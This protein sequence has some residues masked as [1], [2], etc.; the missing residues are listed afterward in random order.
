MRNRFFFVFWIQIF[1]QCSFSWSDEFHRLY[2]GA[3]A[4][5]M[6][7]AF[8]AVAD[9]EEAIFYNPAGLAGIEKLGL[10]LLASDTDVSG[11]LLCGLNDYTSSF[12]NPSISTIRSMI[13]KKLY[14]REQVVST[15]LLPR[16]GFALLEDLQ[17][18]LRPKNVIFPDIFLGVQNTFGTQFAFGM[19]IKRF[20]NKRGELRIGLAAKMLWRSGGYQ[21]FPFEQ[22][23]LLNSSSLR[24]MLNQYGTGYGA[25]AGMQIIYRL[26]KVF[27]LMGGV[28]WTDIGDTSFRNGGDPQKSNLTF[29]LAARLQKPAFATTLSYDYSHVLNQID[30]RK[31]NHLG[32]ELKF[33]LLRLYG[34]LN[35]FFYTYGAGLDLGFIS[36]MGLSYVEEQAA[37]CLQDPETRYM[38]HL[39]LKF[40]L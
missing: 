36:V 21:D 23:L 37:L 7:G 26:S 16:F 30:W 11:D 3:R 39:A 9:D 32:L 22:L 4:Q 35:Q 25:D 40:E 38:L 28:A 18:A 13:G 20:K 5:A 6:G 31:K 14:V 24:G 10:N 15:L 34:G 27:K 33:P 29:G 8:T 19:P 17:L 2:R 12:S 1:F